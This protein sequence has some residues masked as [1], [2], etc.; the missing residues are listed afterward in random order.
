MAVE[1][2]AEARSATAGRIRG[3]T[4]R[5]RLWAARYCYLL[6]V[7]GL[8]LIGM[9]SV[10]P[11]VMSWYYS[12]LD[13][14][15]I[16]KRRT[17]IGLG[18]FREL[19]HDSYFW[20]AF[21]RSIWFAGVASP[22]ELILSLIVAIILNER[23]LRLGPLYRTLFFLPVVTT[24]AIVSIVMSFVFSTFN[25][26]VNQALQ[27]VNVINA[28]I[29]FLTDHSVVMWTAIGIFVWKWMGQPM[30]YWLAGLQTI[31]GE[32]YEAARVDGARWW[33]QLRF[34][35]LPLL[36]PFTVIITLIVVVGNMQVFA[37][38]QA[39]THGGPYFSTETM[40][41]YIFR[42]AFGASTAGSVSAV[43]LGYA[44]AAGVLFGVLVI[45]LAI[46][47]IIAARRLRPGARAPQGV[48]AR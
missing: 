1:L 43:R 29:G 2:T 35:T 14:D 3:R 38:L 15:G 19:V 6:M 12:F 10:Y 41:L 28:P 40:E 47:Q 46:A 20:D 34:V 33:H 26:P 25:G 39:L 21:W 18:N 8:I 36:T 16:Q 45:L 30:I 48:V 17:W 31:P 37:F 23:A 32:L 22:A 27:G 13:W 4:L 5:E 42:M 11:L 9:F 44:S 24:T 7:P